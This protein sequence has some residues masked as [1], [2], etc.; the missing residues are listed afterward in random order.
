MGGISS[1][2]GRL[3]IYHNNAWGTI[4]DDGFGIMD[5]NVACKQLG[6]TTARFYY[7]HVDDGHESKKIW[8]EDL[9]C[10]GF[11]SSLTSCYH[12]GWGV[13]DCKHSEDIGVSCY[14][15][16]IYYNKH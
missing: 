13:H 12:R 1:L 8:L 7:R 2:Q 5:A 6:Y 9:H 3:E 15:G 4:C 10:S 16:I 11:E 14:K